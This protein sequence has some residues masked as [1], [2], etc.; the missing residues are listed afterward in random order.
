MEFNYL[1]GDCILSTAFVSYMGPFNFKCRD[2][3][4][5]LWLTFIKDNEIP[6]N[7]NFDVTLFLTDPE[8]IRSWNNY[9][10]SNDRFS[11]ENGIIISSSY[12]CPFIIDPQSQAWKWINNIES[13]NRIQIIDYRSTNNTHNLEIALENGYPILIQTDFKYLD[14]S[15][16]SI[17]SKSIVKQSK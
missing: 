17:L 7:S 8:T 16:V 15:I 11:L 9:G 6:N 13:K 5:N 12:R 14:L 1:L 10:L 3:L 2:F 4:M